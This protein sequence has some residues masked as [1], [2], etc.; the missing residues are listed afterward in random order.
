MP[1]NVVSDAVSAL[2]T[3]RSLRFKAFEDYSP[4]RTRGEKQ[5]IRVSCDRSPPRQQPSHFGCQGNARRLPLTAVFYD[6]FIDQ[7]NGDVVPHGI[8]AVT[9]AALQALTRF[10]LH[11]RLLAHGTYQNVEQ[12]LRNHSGILPPNGGQRIKLLVPSSSSQLANR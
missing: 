9:L 5:K 1:Q 3:L 8:D 4:Q 6:R 11:K 2:R 7:Q 12:F 10:L